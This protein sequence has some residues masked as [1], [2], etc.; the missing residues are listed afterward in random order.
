MLPEALW[1]KL[2]TSSVD[3]PQRMDTAFPRG[4]LAQS[5]QSV[6]RRVQMAP[7]GAV[8]EQ[9]LLGGVDLNIN[10]SQGSNPKSRL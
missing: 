9:K 8:P 10:G 3:G 5:V 2:F 1:P 6:L 7:P 4:L